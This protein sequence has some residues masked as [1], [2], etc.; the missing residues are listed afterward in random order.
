MMRKTG[1]SSR[2]AH[3]AGCIHVLPELLNGSGQPTN[4]KSGKLTDIMINQRFWKRVYL[5]GIAMV[6]MFQEMIS[7]L[8]PLRAP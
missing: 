6:A 2:L 8:W 1:G 7:H 3:S 5:L 4:C